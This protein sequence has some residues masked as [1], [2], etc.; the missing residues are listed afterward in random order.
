MKLHIYNIYTSTEL[1]SKGAK[2]L[3]SLIKFQVTNL[4]LIVIAR[5]VTNVLNKWAKNGLMF[6]KQQNENLGVP[7]IE[8]FV[9]EH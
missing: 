4:C 1:R 8:V 3:I 6:S 7:F 2:H 9:W 5:T